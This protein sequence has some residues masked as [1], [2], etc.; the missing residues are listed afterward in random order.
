MIHGFLI[1]KIARST[2]VRG[3]AAVVLAKMKEGKGTYGYNAA[4]SEYGEPTKIS[5][6][7]I[8]LSLLYLS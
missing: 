1:T 5:S 8:K 7:E 6:F 2:W 3:N 4:T